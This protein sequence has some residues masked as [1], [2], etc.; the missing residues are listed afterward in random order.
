MLNCWTGK[1][2][3]KEKKSTGLAQDTIQTIEIPNYWGVREYKE[4]LETGYVFVMGL[5]LSSSIRFTTIQLNQLAPDEVIVTAKQT[6]S[7]FSSF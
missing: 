1:G 4:N 3:K 7:A 6:H 2:K 5:S